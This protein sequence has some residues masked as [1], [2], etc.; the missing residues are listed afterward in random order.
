MTATTIRIIVAAALGVGLFVVAFFAP[1]ASG[2]DRSQPA[3]EIV[4]Y[5]AGKD[6]RADRPNLVVVAGPYASREE[7]RIAIASVRLANG[8]RLR[9]DR[10]ETRRVR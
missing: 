2:A 8:K 7:C 5:P 4:A 9:C 3:F 10:I 6:L 1:R